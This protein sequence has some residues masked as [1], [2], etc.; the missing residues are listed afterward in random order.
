MSEEIPAGYYT[1]RGVKGSEQFGTTSNGNRQIAINLDVAELGRELTTFLVFSEK[2]TPYETERLRALGWTGDDKLTGIDANEVTVA[3]KYEPYQG[4]QKMKVQIVTGGGTVKLKDTMDEK[5]KRSFLVE[6]S[7]I[8]K[9]EGPR[10]APKPAPKPA[11]GRALPPAS[12]GVAADYDGGD[13]EIPFATC[14]VVST[15]RIP[16]WERW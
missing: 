2:N 9:S 5:Q 10:T 13:D 3:V 16:K 8:A 12:G 6:L 1:A 11:N 15:Q 4:E 7:R 14:A